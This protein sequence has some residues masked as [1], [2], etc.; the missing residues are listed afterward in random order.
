MSVDVQGIEWEWESCSDCG[1]TYL[2]DEY[3]DCPLDTSEDY[4]W[5]YYEGPKL[6]VPEGADFA[7]FWE[8]IEGMT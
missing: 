5:E 1:E 6:K 7:L 3:H 8:P 4:G 2:A